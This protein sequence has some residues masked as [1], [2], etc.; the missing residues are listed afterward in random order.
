[1]RSLAANSSAR[2][3]SLTGGLRMR[4]MKT[5]ARLAM[6]RA[7]MSQ[8]SKSVP[9]FRVEGVEG[10]ALHQKSDEI[11]RRQIGHGHAGG[12]RGAGDVRRQDDVGHRQQV[13]VDLGLAF[14]N[15]EP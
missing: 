15:V 14:E 5:S 9:H 10:L 12:N 2:A 6:A 4:T 11:V 7:M 3:A 8:S 1:M 13:G